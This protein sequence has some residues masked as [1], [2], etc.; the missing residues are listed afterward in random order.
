MLRLLK[1]LLSQCLTKNNQYSVMKKETKKGEGFVLGAATA[2]AAFAGYYL[3][4]PKGKE[5]RQKVRGWTLKAKGEILEKL[6]KLEDISEE[7]YHTIV[8]GVMAKYKKLKSTTEDETEKLEKEL[9]KRFNHVKKDLR[10]IKKKVVKKVEKKVNKTQA[11]V[12]KKITPKKPAK[13]TKAT[14]ATKKKK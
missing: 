5:N 13:K 6:E 7:K 8:D 10:T 11:K 9:K 1:K 3:F 4:G 2:L 12:A 14:K